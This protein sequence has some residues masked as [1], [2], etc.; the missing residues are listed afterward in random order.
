MRRLLPFVSIVIFTDTMLFAAIIP[1][2]PAFA[3]E[4]GL[5]KLEAGLLVGAY[6]AGA[7][8][9]GIPSG[10]VAGRIGAKRTVVVGLLILSVASVAFGLAASPAALGITRFAQGFA[11]AVTW[12]GALAWLTLTTPRERR[13]QILGTAFGFAVLGFIVGPAVGALAEQ[14]RIEVSFAIVGVVTAA[15]AVAASTFPASRME[16]RAAGSLRR[17]LRDV[18]F[19]A[20]IWLSLLPAF[21]FGVV[22]V[23]VP[24]ALD[25]DGWGS[26]AIAA[27]FVVA[28]LVEVRLAPV[29]G[30]VSDRHG[31]LYPIRLALALLVVVAALLALATPAL[32]VAVLVVG[33]ATATSGLYTPAIALVSDRAERNRMPQ[34]LGFGVMNTTWAF[35]AMAGPVVG[36]ALATAVGDPTPYVLCAVLA[37]ATLLLF[38]LSDREARTA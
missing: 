7:M 5:S 24:L 22:D 4:F 12:S 20:A 11:S 10:L 32:I 27:T 29:M 35:G 3:D 21:F 31:R 26:I 15:L 14:T 8:A 34:T 9:G 17:A 1:L 30:G 18:G 2:I 28:G 23:L 25:E 33:A 37:A 6:G 36:G 38:R 13:G 19:L 16:V